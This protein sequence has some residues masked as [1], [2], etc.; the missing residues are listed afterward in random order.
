M[1]IKVLLFLGLI[2][3]SSAAFSRSMAANLV[4]LDNLQRP[5]ELRQGRRCYTSQ[6]NSRDVK[7]I[8]LNDAK[9]ARTWK[10]LT[11]F[12]LT[13]ANAAPTYCADEE[14]AIHANKRRKRAI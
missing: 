11:D 10:S 5:L 9:K 12:Q 6:G 4:N 8:S 13:L 3:S 2:S 7:A 1:V 14:Y